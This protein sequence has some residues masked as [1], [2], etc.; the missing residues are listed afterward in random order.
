MKR[1]AIFLMVLTLFVGVGCAKKKVTAP[2]KKVIETKPE[3]KEEI[4]AKEDIGVVKETIFTSEEEGIL[5]D[6]HFDFD[7]YEIKDKAKPVL[8]AIAD[9]LITKSNVRITVEGH[10]DERGTNEYNLALGDQRAKAAK[11]YLVSLGVSSDRLEIVSYGEEKPI[12]TE[13][14]EQCWWKNRR[15]HFVLP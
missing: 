12:C 3:I 8:R 4:P 2:E 11:N 1:L 15:A 13:H 6:I 9:L 5:K 7:K 10:C 14:D